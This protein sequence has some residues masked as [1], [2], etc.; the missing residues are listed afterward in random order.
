MCVLLSP[1]GASRTLA[2]ASRSLLQVL[3]TLDIIVPQ[4]G[5]CSTRVGG[6]HRNLIEELIENF[7]PPQPL[8]L[9]LPLP[10]T[11]LPLR[12]LPLSLFLSLLLLPGALGLAALP[13]LLRVALLLL[14][15]DILV[16]EVR[17]FSTSRL[18][19]AGRHLGASL[20]LKASYTCSL[21]PNTIVA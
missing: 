6:T 10:R 16:P 3:C 7:T 17:Y 11:P 20:M 21:R 18:N 13:A 2:P 14:E 12:P 5:Y 15:L 19:G 9:H 8:D 4:V 1:A